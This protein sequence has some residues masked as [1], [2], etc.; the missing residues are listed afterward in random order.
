MVFLSVYNNSNI[1]KITQ[2]IR[3]CASEFQIFLFASVSY[4]TLNNT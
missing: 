2:A 4:N 1:F 3:T